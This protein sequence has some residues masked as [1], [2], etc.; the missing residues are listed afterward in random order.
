MQFATLMGRS[1][2]GSNQTLVA[3]NGSRCA[4]SVKT[5]AAVSQDYDSG[6]V[7]QTHAAKR[8]GQ[9]FENI[10]L[11]RENGRRFINCFESP[12]R[13]CVIPGHGS[14]WR[15]FGSERCGHALRMSPKLL[16]TLRKNIKQDCSGC[17]L[18]ILKGS[19]KNE[20]ELQYHLLLQ[21][22]RRLTAAPNRAGKGRENGRRTRRTGEFERYER[23]GRD[24][25]T[26]GRVDGDGVRDAVQGD[27][28]G[29]SERCRV[30]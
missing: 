23:S 2:N 17:K 11:V 6:Y 10:K 3:V 27:Q 16:I 15:G 8:S 13:H 24:E 7:G 19:L 1:E 9:G 4:P 12:T 28:C 26:R 18:L 22:P 29:N 30:G 14:S 5:G 20:R 21:P 25:H